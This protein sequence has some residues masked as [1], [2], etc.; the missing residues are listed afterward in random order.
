[1]EFACPTCRN[2]LSIPAQ[3][4]N[5]L[6]QCPHCATVLDVSAALAASG[7]V[8][9][10][11][12]LT[13]PPAARTTVPTFQIASASFSPA[14]ES[15]R[16]QIRRRKQSNGWLVVVLLIAAAGGIGW[17]V[18]SHHKSKQQAS[19]EQEKGQKPQ[20]VAYHEA[21]K[22]VRDH[23][24][25]SQPHAATKAQFPDSY[26]VKRRSSDMSAF[27]V[28]GVVELPTSGGRMISKPFD[29]ELHQ[30][31]DNQ[32]KLVRLEIDRDLVFEE[33]RPAGDVPEFKYVHTNKKDDDWIYGGNSGNKAAGVDFYAEQTIS[34]GLKQ[35]GDQIKE[36]MD[37]HKTLVVWLFDKSASASG[38]RNEAMAAL[39]TIYRELDGGNVKSGEK[40]LLT[41]VGAFGKEVEF[42]LEEPT[43]DERE[44]ERAIGEID[45]EES[46]Q[47]RVFSAI[48]AAAEKYKDLRKEQDRFLIIVVVSD[49]AGDDENQIEN[50]M[51]L[52]KKNTIPLFVIGE[53]APFGRRAIAGA[54]L[55][56]ANDLGQGGKPANLMHHG[57]ESFQP[58]LINLAFWNPSYGGD[59]SESL[60]SGFGPYSLTRLA[61]ETHGEYFACRTDIGGGMRS[62]RGAANWNPSVSLMH[63][64]DPKVMAKYAPEYL[65]EKD[66]QDQLKKSKCRQAVVDAAKLPRIETMKFVRT[67]FP[68]AKDE[69]ANAVALGQAQRAAA[70]I[71]PRIEELFKALKPGEADRP[72]ETSPR[73]QAAFD[74]AFGRVLAAK[75]RTEGYNAMLAKAKSGFAFTNEQSIGFK[76]VPSE[77]IE[78]GSTFQKLI[79]DSKK[80]LQRVV[81]DHPGTPWAFLAERELSTSCG[82]KWVEDLPPGA[83]PA[84]TEE[85]K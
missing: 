37:L 84:A 26:K 8:P 31:S 59:D 58:E 77:T 64:F 44:I 57:P 56:V 19:A 38:Y 14:A 65:S 67:D 80:Y 61:L 25:K 2:S 76:L 29:V 81:D 51:S 39:P 10:A 69:A 82:W 42:K 32:W 4:A 62:G 68:R 63:T 50:A 36:S 49:E 7:P 83:A 54:N 35:V 74:L 28:K 6:V 85:S 46:G 75:A 43:A 23:L 72:K 11:A 53:R 3:L 48:I 78:A 12:T 47:E 24:K 20:Q 60:D 55:E 27:V 18:V 40:P 5:P 30:Q 45:Q 22:Y 79:N 13:T 33:E 73:W 9:A 16:R 15:P 21:C 17:F 66:Y 70:P 1:M 41:V 71:E 34:W 52:L